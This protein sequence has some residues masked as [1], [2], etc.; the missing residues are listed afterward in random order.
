MSKLRAGIVGLG[1]R[2]S[3]LLKD[4]LIKMDDVVISAVCDQYEDRVKEAADVV[5]NAVGTRPFECVDYKELVKKEYVDCVLVVTSWRSHIEI[6]KHCME[7]G[8]PV[9]SEVGG[10]VTLDDCYDLV[11]T[12]ERTKTPYMFM[13]N[14]NYGRRELM[15]L[16]MARQGVFGEIVHC[17]GCYAHDLRHEVAFGKEE[18]HYRLYEYLNRNCET[19]PSHELG[20]IMQVLDINRSNRLVS[21]STFCSKAAGMHEYIKTQKPDDTELRDAVFAQGDVVTTVI[22]CENGE[23]VTITL[24]TTLPRYYS[25]GFTV[26]GTKGMYEEVTDSVFVDSEEER[27]KEFEWSKH[28]GNAKDY[29]AEYDDEIWKTVSPEALESGHGGIDWFC[30]KDFFDHVR[31]G[32]PMP[33]DVYDGAV[34]MAITPLSEKSAAAGGIPVEIPDFKSR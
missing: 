11:E 5:E 15:A 34:I 13:E 12:Y 14:C 26:R 33:I 20:P 3:S 23:T 6:A 8:I 7:Q 25:R 21:L 4:V 2:G 28:W 18:R 10:A 22:K 16:N 27:K 32:E 24:D 19:Y 1:A 29:E 30:Y 31:S 17:S 9:G